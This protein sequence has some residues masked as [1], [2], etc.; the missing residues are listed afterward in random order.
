MPRKVV[1]SQSRY[2]LKAR[3]AR[4]KEPGFRGTEVQGGRTILTSEKAAPETREADW[5]G[6]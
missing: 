2:F 5:E 6:L 3:T 1:P 4:Q